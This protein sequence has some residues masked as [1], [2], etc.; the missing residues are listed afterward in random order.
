M[1][2][3]T[4]TRT[5][6]LRA[7]APVAVLAL[8]LTACGGGSD[9][10]GGSTGKKEQGSSESKPKG[11]SPEAGEGESGAM[12][13]GEAVTA[14]FKEDDAKITYE[15]AAQKVDLSTEAEAQKMV[16]DPKDAKGLV[17]ATAHVKFTNKA[18]GVVESSPSVG[19]ETEIYADGAP[20]A[21]LMFASEDAPGCDDT[22]DIDN[23]KAGQSYTICQ[24]YMVPA[25]AKSI[26]VRFPEEGGATHTWTF[27]AK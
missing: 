16:E 23:W 26:E 24:T 18:G 13:A 11:D 15:I 4:P 21:R 17:A 7:A 20:G 19:M 1:S 9:S 25:T 5:R 3:R 22:I 8:A 12:Q 2:R 14:A 27:A 10:G 6:A